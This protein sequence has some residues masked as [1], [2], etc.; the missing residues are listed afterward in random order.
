MQRICNFLNGA[1]SLG[2]GMENSNI[3]FSIG[4][5]Q[6]LVTTTGNNNINKNK[7]KGA[8]KDYLRYAWCMPVAG[9]MCIMCFHRVLLR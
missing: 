6:R 8:A 5:V 4:V 2:N 7:K 9:A 3:C 1:K